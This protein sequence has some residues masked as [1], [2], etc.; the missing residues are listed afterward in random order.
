M[1]NVR[2]PRRGQGLV[3]FVLVTALAATATVAVFRLFRQDLNT[4]Y[5][6][7]GDLLIESAAEGTTP[8]PPAP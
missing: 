8:P 4:A 2:N 3:E 5:E 1:S 6:R 7:V